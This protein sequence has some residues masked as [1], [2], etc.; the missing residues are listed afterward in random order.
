MRGEPF[1]R[2]IR[3][4]EERDARRQ[5]WADAC[6]LEEESEESIGWDEAMDRAGEARRDLAAARLRLHGLITRQRVHLSEMSH[7]IARVNA[8]NVVADAASRHSFY[9]SI[10]R[11]ARATGGQVAVTTTEAVRLWPR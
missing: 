3:R 4:A 1:D 7:T 9:L 10:A 8:E 6:R 2:V 11:K 5:A